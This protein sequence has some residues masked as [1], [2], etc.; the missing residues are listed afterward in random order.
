MKVLFISDAP[1][2]NTGY[3][4]VTRHLLPILA[5]EHEV[6][7]LPFAGSVQGGFSREVMGVEV[8]PT[9]TS[10]HD[11]AFWLF[12]LECDVA[13]VLKDPYAVPGI[14][15][16]PVFHI[17]YSP[18]AEE[19]V[20]GEWMDIASNAIRVWIPSMWGVE[21]Y[22][23]SGGD[24]SKVRYLPHGVST[25]TYK[26]ILD[27]PRE[28]LRAKLNPRLRDVDV[29]IGLVAVN[30]QR[31]L[32][33]N[34]L[35]AIKV[36][37]ERNPD[38][39]V[40]IYLH[41]SITPDGPHGGWLLDAVVKTMG[42]EGKVV[43]PEQHYYRLGFSEAEM[44]LVYNALDVLLELSTEGFGLPILEAESAGCPVITLDHG[45]GPEINFLGLNCRVSARCY[46]VRGSW[47]G[48]PDPYHAAE[49]IERALSFDRVKAARLLHGKAK[50]FDWSRVAEQAAKLLE[51]ASEEFMP[52]RVAVEQR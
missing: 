18:I 52:Q 2:L 3:A 13:V 14:Q 10:V 49:L 11:I 48:I 41:T 44:N 31:K 19:P 27:T 51:E 26:P 35:E 38:L 33:P 12:R 34:Q 46:T 43:F 47:W 8:L 6:I 21:Q 16:L 32:I 28:E 37:M 23:R 20:P 29:V 45:A 7:L 4:T 36:F 30:R 5:G 22:T 9:F 1:W 17:M 50:A 40:G 39:K 42:L 25:D 24:R 15:A